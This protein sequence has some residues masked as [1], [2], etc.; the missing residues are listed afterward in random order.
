M[1]SNQ[2]LHKVL[3]AAFLGSILSA[4][5]PVLSR[6][7]VADSHS[8][9]PHDLRAQVKLFYNYSKDFEAIEQPLHGEELQVVDFWTK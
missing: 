8:H 5:F 9:N 1:R 6:G 4:T 2:N 7:Q 3:V